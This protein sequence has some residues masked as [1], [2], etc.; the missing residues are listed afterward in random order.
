MEAIP[1]TQNLPPVMSPEERSA[2]ER[3]RSFA[4]RQESMLERVSRHFLLNFDAFISSSL[5]ILLESNCVLGN[6]ILAGAAT[7]W[8]LVGTGRPNDVSN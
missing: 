1:E 8:N 4:R 3:R 5:L 2:A 7:H 6:C